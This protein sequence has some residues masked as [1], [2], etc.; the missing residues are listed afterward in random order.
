MALNLLSKLLGLWS[1]IMVKPSQ[2][3]AQ[4]PSIPKFTLRNSIWLTLVPDR[5]FRS[6][7]NEQVDS[8]EIRKI[9]ENLCLYFYPV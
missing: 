7:K 2:L 1:L 9:Y 6:G 8:V 5:R 4:H 3:R